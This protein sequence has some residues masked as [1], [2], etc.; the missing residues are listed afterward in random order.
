[1]PSVLTLTVLLLREEAKGGLIRNF[2]IIVI[3][4]LFQ[5]FA[6]KTS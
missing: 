2:I 6:K 1:M 4:S 5:N 3:M